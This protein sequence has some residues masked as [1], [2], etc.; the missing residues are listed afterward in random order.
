M[1]ISDTSI[2]RPVLATMFILGLVVMGIV[3]Y[4]GIGVDLFPKVEFPVVTVTTTLKGASPEIMDIDVTDKIEEAVNT[5]NGVKT[6]TSTSFESVSLVNVEFELEQDIDLAVQDVR[7]KIAAVRSR[8]PEDISEPV[9]QKENTESNPVL[10]LTL[11]GSKSQVE[12][13]TYADEILK[14][15]LQKIQGVGSIVMAGI[16]K[17]QIRIWLDA[18][19]LR[20]F[21]ISPSDVAMALS[22]EN[23]ELPG[24]RIES[25]TKEFTIK[26]KGSL[27]NVSEFN[28]LIVA[29]VQGASVRIRDIG[30]A[31]DG[32]EERRSYARYNGMSCIG[33]GIQKQTGTNTV[34]VVDR[35]KGRLEHIRKTLP[36]GMELSIAFD[37]STYIV[38]SM[39]Q[40][41]EHLILGSILA[42]I[43]VFLFL[44]NVRTTLISAVAL[45]VSIISTFALMRAFGFTFNNLTML[46]LTLSVGIL[47]DDAIIV[48]ENIYRHIEEG[49][50]PREAASYATSEIG[51]AVLATTFAIVV[52]FLPV[53]FMKGVIGQFFIQFALTVVFSILV[54]LLV[55]LT[56]T[57][58]LSSI[59]LHAKKPA[60]VP[61][62]GRPAL[63]NRFWNALERWYKKIEHMYRRILEYSLDHRGAVLTGAFVLFILSMFLV[64]FIGMEFKPQYDQGQFVVRLEAP[65]DY[66]M[67]KAIDMF[68]QAEGIVR[69]VPEINGAFFAQGTGLGTIGQINKSFI[70]TR[71]VP[72]SARDRS[73]QEIMVDLRRQL[74]TIPGLKSTI[75]EVAILGG[76]LRNVPVQYVISGGSPEEMSSYAKQIAAEFAKKPGI[77]DVDTS[78]ETGKPELS[79]LIDREKA[80]D[81]G[82][83]TASIAEAVNILIS[84][85]VEITKFKDEAKG[86]RYDVR[87]RLNPENRTSPEDIGKLYI[88]AMDGKLV[89]LRNVVS[90]VE[91]GGPSTI[92]RK[93]RQ[94][95][96]WVFANLEGK[97][98]NDAM[99]D[100]DGI[101]SKILPPGYS[102]AYVGEAE[103]MGRSFNYLLF[104]ILLGVLLAYMIL[105]GQFESFLDP[106]T[107]LLA[108]PLSFI[109]A[110]GALLLM[111]KTISIVSFIGIILLM[112]LVKKNSILLVDYTNTL[113]KAG[114]SRREALLQAGPVRLRPIL[115]TTFAMVFGMIPVAF[116]VGEGSD[117][118]SPMGIT[119]IGGLLTSL[120]LTLAVVPAAYDLFD[121]WKGHLGLLVKSRLKRSQE[122]V[123]PE[124]LPEEGEPERKVAGGRR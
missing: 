1:W 19:K 68:T 31:E 48:I 53:A 100:L 63:K 97:P 109:G 96:L 35:I 23:I 11:T 75:E 85:E 16:Q 42:V 50:S 73:Q 120:F 7:E 94:R 81:L 107:V 21:G 110:F 108:M 27:K 89:E 101:S 79:V 114:M 24:G 15:Q 9:I 2:R 106:V 44:R 40:V 62:D 71:L 84:G 46:A 112:G 88:R 118:R 91:G 58:M 25:D 65:P 4:P 28:D 66:S 72:R 20:A 12:L 93:D 83:S 13:S 74:G 70:V 57:P 90:I 41:Q 102:T 64:R 33:I 8:L 17:R 37:Q 5:I 98:L 86:R 123:A 103:E 10:W 92:I 14:E 59:F 121:D 6:I 38:D 30:R 122:Q 55:S 45:P 95:S 111:G 115:M 76:G 99:K 60:V 34:Q 43:A 113:R 116:G 104:A 22:R 78:L 32:M 51:P 56:L 77:V 29:Y 80:S 47:I 26:V 82:V 105:A 49:M 36:P 61:A 117:I 18:E 67:K 54:S 69:A 52:I 124:T 39:K 3:S 87:V 119:V